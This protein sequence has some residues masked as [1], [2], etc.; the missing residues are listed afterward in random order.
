MK[1]DHWSKLTHKYFSVDEEECGYFEWYDEELPSSWYKDNVNEIKF[2]TK[3]FPMDPI[4]SEASY[5]NHKYVVSYEDYDFPAVS[6][7]DNPCRDFNLLVV[8]SLSC[9]VRCVCVTP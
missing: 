7:F 3:H 9:L 5:E 1:V 4:I 2:R 8:Q 6:G